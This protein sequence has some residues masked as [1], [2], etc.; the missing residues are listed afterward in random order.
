M[1]RSPG[2]TVE[3]KRALA[4]MRGES[5]SAIEDPMEDIFYAMGG[6]EGYVPDDSADLAQSAADAEDPV[7][8]ALRDLLDSRYVTLRL[9]PWPVPD[10]C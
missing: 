4:E 9:F 7:A 2:M 1:T 3:Q 10:A 6:E 5:S 8:Y